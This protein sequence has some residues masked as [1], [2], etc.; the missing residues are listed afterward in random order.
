MEEE[1]RTEWD[2]GDRCCPNH[3]L[4]F[5][6]SFLSPACI[7]FVC[8]KTILNLAM[9]TIIDRQRT[10]RR[11]TFEVREI[12]NREWTRMGTNGRGGAARGL[13][14]GLLLWM[15][16]IS[17]VEAQK[18]EVPAEN[19]PE[20][21]ESFTIRTRSEL[22]REVPFYLR[23]PK[24][25]R[26]GKAYRLLFLCPYLNQEGLKKLADSAAWLA[27]ADAEDWF[28]MSCTLKQDSHAAKDRKLAY[29]YPEGFS[30][31]ATL[32]ALETVSKKYPVDTERLL[33]QGL[34]GGAQFVHRFA[35][36]VPERVTAV[37]VNSSSWFDTPSPRCN[38]VAWLVTIG[39]SDDTYHLSLEVV[40]RLRTVGAAPLF[41][42]YLGMVHEGSGAVDELSMEFLKFYDDFTQNELGKRRSHQAPAAERFS[43]VG[44]KMPYVGDGQDWK[45]FP[46][47]PEA[48]ESVADDSRIYLPSES[49]AKLWGKK[50]EE[51]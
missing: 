26:P 36:W 10:E 32:E 30:G 24:N 42:S 45:F 44:E 41:R 5:G 25:Y 4:H 50:E 13:A 1:I 28:V 23:V 39:E 22:N 20:R 12:F 49:I 31:K 51:P 27:L 6:P 38:Q 19:L 17:P 35:M 2:R 47:T 11:W 18:P 21:V 34:S 9:K 48:R 16:L 40:D 46:N 37:A 8:H 14:M 15:F 43:L 3:E 29:Y 33:M 7:L